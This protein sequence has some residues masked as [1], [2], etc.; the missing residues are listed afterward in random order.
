MP[1]QK[2]KI[3]SQREDRFSNDCTLLGRALYPVRSS[4]QKGLGVKAFFLALFLLFSLS[5]PSPGEGMVQYFN[6]TWR[7]IINKIPELSEAG[8]ES[9]WLPPPTKGSG[10]LSVGY[11]LWDR[12]DLGS[13]DQR[14]S[15]RTRYGT[16]QELIELIRVAHR[17]GIRVYFD[18]IMNHNAFDIPGFN[19]GVPIDIYPGLVPEDFHLRVTEEGYYRKWDNTRNWGDAWQVMHL[20]L[21]D[22][23]D[24]AT[25]PGEWNNNHGPSEG[26]RIKKIS[27]VRHPN[28]P[29]YYCYKP[30]AGGQKHSLGQGTYV[31]FGPG[32]GITVA[33]LAADPDFYSELV[34][35]M[36]HRSARWLIAT[37]YCDGLRLD[38][39]KHTPADFFGAT[40]GG[41]KDTS[42][43]GY[44]G[45]IQRQFNLTNGFTDPNH[46]DTVFDTQKPRDDAM[47]FGEHLG[48]PPSYQSYVDAGMR[49]VDNELRTQFNSRLG[50]PSSG[51]NGYD[52]PGWGGF[53]PNVAVMHAQSHDNDYAA[54]R[55]LQHAFYF[56]RAGLP[57]VYTDGNYQAETL[58]QSGGAF[59]RHAN[60]NFL[61]QYADPRLPNLAFLHQHFARGYQV[62][63]WSD[64]DFVAYE[65]I[66]KRE[67][68]GMTDADGVTG[69]I[70]LN[71]NYASGQARSFAT[72]F[73]AV[74]GT[75]NDAYLWQYATGPGIGNFYTFASALNTHTVPP[76]G[77]FI[78]SW[79]T[80]E[81]SPHWKSAGGDPV[82][83]Y[84][85]GSP[86]GTVTVT[87]KDG[88]DGDPGYNPKGLNDPD[89]T[90]Y[91]YSIE[92]PRVTDGT[93]LRFVARADGSAE[94][95]LL[96][97]DA[98]IDLNGTSGHSDH[99]LRD[100]PP[101]VSTDVFVGYEQPTFVHR[102][103]AEKFAAVDT[104]RCQI[105]SSGAETYI[106]TVGS[107]TVTVV[108]GAGTNPTP[109]NTVSFLYH[110]P[111]ALVESPPSGT[112]LQYQENAGDITFWAKSNSG[113]VGYN[114][115][116][117]YTTDGTNPEGYG[118]EGTGSTQTIDMNWSHDA[119]GGSW[120]SA[121][122]T[123]KPSGELRYKISMFR[124]TDG[125]NPLASVFPAGPGE[126]DE[127]LGMMTVFE[128][129]NFDA[130]TATFFPHANFAKT[131]DGSAF[132]TETGLEEGFHMIRGRA[133]LNRPGKASLFNTFFQT[134]Y[135]DTKRPEGEVVFP[136]EN[137]TLTQQSYGAVVRTDRNVDEVWFF[138]DDGAGPNDDS[139]TG[140]TNGNGIGN[141]VQASEV[142]ST[143][144]ISSSYP[145]EWRFNYTNIPSGNIATKLQ[146]RL[147]EKS[148]ADSSTFTGTVSAADDTAN[149]YTTLTRNV[150]ANGPDT[151]VFIAFPPSDGD[152]VGEGYT[153]KVYF[154]K[155]IGDGKS[156]QEL[157]DEF[158]LTIAS[159]VSGSTEGAE[160]QDRALYSIVR[161]ET[162]DYHALAFD[163]PNLYNG[164]PDFV[165]HI[166]ATHTRGGV[167]LKADRKVKAQVVEVP[168][169]S[170]VTP[171]AFGVDGRPHE[172]E[173][174]AVA[175]PIPAQRE[176]PIHIESDANVVELDIVWEL[177]SGTVSHEETET[178][179]GKK[180]WRYLWTGVDEGQYRFRV[181]AKEVAAGPVVASQR[182]NATVVFRQ[183][184][185]E[186]PNDPDDDDDGL[187]DED[188]TTRADLPE[189]NPET[190]TNGEVHVWRAY[191]Q[192]N[193][194]TP[195]TDNDLLPDALEVGW[196]GVPLAQQG[197]S[198]TDSGYGA[199]NIGTGNLKFDWDDANGNEVHDAGE[200]SEPFAD[201]DSDNVFDYG[202]IMS[203]DTDGDGTPN[204]KAD[205]DPPYFNTVPDNNNLPNYNF[206]RGRTEQI[207]GS[208]TD[209]QNPDSD[210][211]GIIDGI[212]DGY[213]PDWAGGM[214]LDVLV[215]NGWVD[216][217]GNTLD[218]ND[219]GKVW[220][221]GTVDVG[222]I[223][224]ETDPNNPDSDGDG[225]SDGYGED[226]DLNGLITGDTN[227]NRNYDAGEAWSETDPLS[228]DTDGDGL[229]DGWEAQNGLDPLDN[230]TD[231]LGTAAPGDGD[232]VNGA[233][234]DPDN[235]TFSNI[236]EQTSGTKPLV[237]DASPDPPANSITVGP[238]TAV[239]VGATVNGNEFADWSCADLISFDE[240]EGEGGN[241][242]AGDINIAGDG[243]DS[244]RDIVAFFARDG[245][246]DGNYYF[247][248]DFYDLQPFAED[249]NLDTYIVIDTGNAASGEAA[250][251]DEVDILTE[252][253]WEAVVACYSGN[254]GRVYVDTNPAVN[255][256]SVNQDLTGAGVQVR[257]QN[258]GNGF[259]AAYFNSELDAME[260]SISRQAL[261]DAGWNGT[262]KLRYQVF[263][264]RD[265]TQ[266]NGSG[267]GDLG[268]R[269]DIRDT[270]TDDWLAEDYWSSQDY[271]AS[272]GILSSYIEADGNGRYPDHCKRAKLIL[273]THANHAIRPGSETQ[274]K[275]NTGYATGWHRTLDV[276]EAFNIPL[277]LHITPTLASAVQW[278]AV[279]PAAGKPWL[280]GPAF[281]SRIS[282]L[283]QTGEINLLGTTYSD[284]MPAYFSDDYNSDNVTLASETLSSIYTASP[285]SN[286]FWTPERVADHDVFGKIST[287]GFGYT[288]IDQ[289]RHLWKWEG[290]NTALSDDGYRLNR[291]HGITCFLIN[292]KASTYR[293]QTHDN[294]LPFPLR[295]LYLRKAR[296]GTQDQVVVLYHHW[297]EMA[298]V[299]NAAAY[300]T[301]LRWAAAKPWIEVVTPDQIASDQVD[302]DG[303][304]SG[305]SWFVIDRGAPSLATTSHDWLDHATQEDYDNWYFGAGGS[306]EG[307]NPKVFNIRSGVPLS[308]PFGHQGNNDSNVADLAWDEI[309]AMTS[310][311][312]RLGRAGRS[313]AHGATALTAFHNQQNN[314]LSKH[315]TG[316]YIWI[317]SDYNDLSDIATHAQSQMRFAAL[318]R[319]VELWAAT[320]PATAS[321]LAQDIDFDG[322]NEYIL[323]NDRVFA[324]FEA[325]GGRL[326]AAWSREPASGE[327]YQIIGNFSSYSGS[328]TE[329]EGDAN[330]TGSFVNAYRTSGFKDWYASGPETNI[331]I[332]DLYNVT[333]AGASGW[334]LTSSDG[335][336]SKTISLG[337]SSGKL[338]ASYTL[339]GDVT[340]LYVRFGLSPHLSDLLINGQRN[341]VPA[342]D[343]GSRVL[344]SNSG[345]FE[346]V[347]AAVHYANAS[348]GAA[349]T[350]KAAPDFQPDTVKMRNQAQTEQVELESTATSFTLELEL[351]SSDGD[352]DED[353]LPDAWETAN[354]LS[355]GDDG[356]VDPNNGPNGDP[357]GDGI[358]NLMEFLA[359]TNAQVADA[360]LF[361]KLT[362]IVNADQ[363]VTLDFPTQGDRRYRLFWSDDL[364]TWQQLG[365]DIVTIGEA[366]DPHRQVIDTGVPGTP[367][368]PSGE[369]KRFYRLEMMLP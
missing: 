21:S 149:W 87:R 293:Y 152:V 335:K 90:D 156:D 341:L 7:E 80:P 358:N 179:G 83:I 305:D 188:E 221:N 276:H 323:K 8:Y 331:Y 279:D 301:N 203:R 85:N 110:D 357:D 138:I 240:R 364:A 145:K 65:R 218:R 126:V 163:L 353:G 355:P 114:A 214:N 201:G 73:P 271:I 56:T 306:E 226:K 294:G 311:D 9:I 281:N 278:A 186:D 175:N 172:V 205:L 356:S 315:S 295:N 166:N 215:H 98:G 91:A 194:L 104:A 181:D 196:G 15:V 54:R 53:V 342:N 327:V 129:D 99:G 135:Y 33:D 162:A 367:T 84:E 212:E 171:P 258:S 40:F 142:T 109:N 334:T 343:D 313:V 47:L 43:Y 102:Q 41:D 96:K 34:E 369:P 277:T 316:D 161:D 347:D 94:N 187:L 137:D 38:A 200:T 322:A 288:F 143:P 333:A 164:Q 131:P 141:W 108:N 132:L 329:E 26:S 147:V 122:L 160:A 191:G 204:F 74:G 246:A 95:I 256:T 274:E 349:A 116:V 123:P 35:D 45:Q 297:D 308:L 213:N 67:N 338:S 202:T 210:G 228:S 229:L 117:Y 195:D 337:D 242:Q 348:Y 12:F 266:N 1:P 82:S 352:A 359:G 216:G 365:P 177:G 280:D 57:L 320:P 319:Q 197:E 61:G 263:T 158:L 325:S 13:I 136:A 68:G 260:M 302:I 230:G 111:A 113:L 5:S 272:N 48:Q 121:S 234:G 312:S 93:N 106:T 165:H 354:G 20:G 24:L 170:I 81:E 224:I 51:L 60:T 236:Q 328:E 253:K 59:P 130:T 290:R 178:L 269:N 238:G 199:N 283:A 16:Q 237:S 241:N 211:D 254:V 314:D 139:Q 30:S 317:D 71:D 28:N 255:T 239:T 182:R 286:V 262:S 345:L 144:S 225:L 174:P 307:L 153:M 339:G 310:P 206:N 267:A 261:L 31:G 248:L 62:G 103:G 344:V 134:F 125:S 64:A 25:E 97:L 250:L 270:I 92:I 330:A 168:F 155:S 55:E 361:P 368:H 198:F 128:V 268:G 112:P 300:D 77:Y 180:I 193:P 29:E 259:G 264:T 101:A 3:T 318:Y 184:L 151:R 133:F 220:P 118:G 366:P 22:L 46:R 217:D 346:T 207:H 324:V 140:T 75:S 289:M 124:T 42:D 120:F 115:R 27:F 208:S 189:T 265:G 275:I 209:P 233:N 154:S 79:R 86:V 23:I 350:D 52:Q 292:D 185:P 167:N 298:D 169:L 32:N 219:P 222:E 127:K 245:G 251:P 88:P 18:N 17:F 340:K 37:T 291:Y 69:L 36:L 303:D 11:D 146:V 309:V 247:R 243:Y 326:T 119:G 176:V 107:G 252:M 192:S 14:G 63:R 223:W 235:D 296:S 282:T 105:G 6:T 257:D 285:S 363:S 159:R 157:I 58:S 321:G 231:N 227:R 299:N 78:F 273:L 44:T 287:L 173:L 70:M 336:I 148:S 190:W 244:S 332:N 284:H 304:G 89:S 232:P 72:S 100:N 19:A 4:V 183:I 10:G 249:G 50:N 362:M 351:A 39:V 49:L 360:H 76:G 2:N 150:V 66:D